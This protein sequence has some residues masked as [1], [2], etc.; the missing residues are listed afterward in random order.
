MFE[1]TLI[2]AVLTF[3]NA[4]L[5]VTY[6]RTAGRSSFSTIDDQQLAGLIMWIPAGIVYAAAV[7]ALLVSVLRDE[8]SGTNRRRHTTEPHPPSVARASSTGSIPLVSRV[9]AAMAV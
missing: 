3:A 4:P 5:Y 8:Q 9:R 6:A 7:L 1:G 2:G